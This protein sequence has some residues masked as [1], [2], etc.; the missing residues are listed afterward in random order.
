M[1]KPS[2][3]KTKNL[4]ITASHKA[5]NDEVWDIVWE[6]S[7]KDSAT[8]LF[9]IRFDGKPNELREVVMTA[10]EALWGNEY[11]AEALKQMC[12]WAFSN[13]S[14]YYIQAHINP[15]I[16]QQHELLSGAGF[17]LFG[18]ENPDTYELEKPASAYI[19][20]FMC[21]GLSMGMC[22]GL[23]FD[24]MAIGMCIGIAIGAAVGAALDH[25]DKAKRKN[26][27]R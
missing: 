9:K 1:T 6:V 20:I 16:Q 18:E 12:E 24:N 10:D 26:N 13:D 17:V 14:C 15:D 5:K 7:K 11:A 8:P 25:A 19:S 23:S 4:I 2:E 21:L 27:K 22:L 3:M